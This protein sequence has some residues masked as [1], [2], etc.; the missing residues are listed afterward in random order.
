MLSSYY[1]IWFSTKGRRP[2]LE[3]EIH[4]EA[5]KLLVSAAQR[6]GIALLELQLD[7]DHGHLLLRIAE[8]QTL[9]DVVRLLKGSGARHLFL[10]FP[11]MKID[12][13]SFWQKGYGS[14]RLTRA[15]LPTVK[16]Y[17]VTHK[18]RP[19]RHNA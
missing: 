12:T 15:Q 4:D 8:E 3:D 13:T 9:P 19:L 1:H 16:R 10:K 2:V 14:R 11:E 18:E 7:A 5:C 17:I 6:H